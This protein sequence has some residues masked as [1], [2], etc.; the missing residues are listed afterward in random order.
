MI[1]ENKN[2]YPLIFADAFRSI[3]DSLLNSPSTP[4]KG[5]PTMGFLLVSDFHSYEMWVWKNS[6]SDA[7]K[8]IKR[9][10]FSIGKSIEGDIL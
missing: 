5:N 4:F 8:S 9:G 7:R 6:L 1:N 10:V 2:N 3:R